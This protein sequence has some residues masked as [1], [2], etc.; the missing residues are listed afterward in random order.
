LKNTKVG[1][2]TLLGESEN[3][4]LFGTNNSLNYR[5]YLKVMQIAENYFFNSDLFKKT[6][7]YVAEREFPVLP[8][9]V[10]SDIQ[11]AYFNTVLLNNFDSALN[12]LGTGIVIDYKYM[13]SFNQDDK[14]PKYKR[15]IQ[16]L[17]TEYWNKDSHESEG[18]EK[19]EDDLMKMIISSIPS[20][21][22][23]GVTIDGMM[24]TKQLY[25]LGSRI[26]KFELENYAYLKKNF[27]KFKPFNQNSVQSL[28][29]Y[30][31]LVSDPKNKSGIF[32]KLFEIKE[33]LLSLDKFFKDNNVEEKEKNSKLSLKSIITQVLN[34]NRGGIYAFYNASGKLEIKEMSN[35]DFQ[36]TSF[37]N[38]VYNKLADS[39]E[40]DYDK[41]LVDTLF[42]E[43]DDERVENININTQ[44]KISKFFKSKFGSG[45]NINAFDLMIHDMKNF[46]SKQK[47][48]FET[49]SD[50]KNALKSLLNAAKTAHPKVIESKQDN[51]KAAHGDASV[52]EYIKEITSNPLFISYRNGWLENYI[53]RPQ[54]NIS[55]LTGEKMPTFKTTNLTYKDLELFEVHEL[56]KKPLDKFNS[57]LTSAANIDGGPLL[58]TMIKLEAISPNG[59]R[60]KSADK[61]EVVENF[62]SNF[63]FDFLK[64]LA[65][66]DSG[67]SSFGVMLGNYSDKSTILLKTINA[68][69]VRGNE[70]E[71]VISKSDE[72]LKD[73]IRRQGFDFYSDAV[74]SVISDYYKIFNATQ[75]SLELG[76]LNI[77]KNSELLKLD[78]ID[79]NS[80]VQDVINAF[81]IIDNIL[82]GL[83]ANNLSIYDINKLYL[84]YG[85]SGSPLME[86]LHYTTYSNKSLSTNRQLLSNYTIFSS[87]KNFEVFTKRTEDKFL[88]DYAAL[89]SDSNTLEI[90][91]E[92]ANE[93][94][95]ITSADKLNI[96]SLA[97][98]NSK[99]GL[100]IKNKIGELNPL[101]KK[102]IWLNALYRNEYHFIS[103]KGEYMH[104]HKNKSTYISNIDVKNDD[105]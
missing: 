18:S 62:K 38:W 7:S 86:E 5:E 40:A 31:T 36:V 33:I 34:N 85:N 3:P 47:I 16:G 48:K 30:T 4:K 75:N 63:L 82:D 21:K 71:K 60:N 87:K 95:S 70:K 20:Y 58:G 22:K 35:Y 29:F 51:D 102:W 9:D 59:Q 24:E 26:S 19:H 23:D 25:L 13:G 99:D 76:K 61:F 37:N 77:I 11:S 56:N 44:L 52:N 92:I 79:A 10:N 73:L 91:I 69:F 43:A 17:H 94:K 12:Q 28:D 93:L 39:L 80:D 65:M 54:M 78:K 72:D 98:F 27:P 67:K 88:S 49:I 45:L 6:K 101:L 68:E 103:A 66:D 15:K 1:G 100:L 14:N 53:V 42:T 41:T 90:P 50:F 81:N 2:I 89:V 8:Y 104:P 46:R 97:G 57:L 74:R 55:T 32:E 96:Q 64:Q 83:T 105:F 84:Q